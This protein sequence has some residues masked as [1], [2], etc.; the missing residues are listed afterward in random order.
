[1]TP[2]VGIGFDAHPFAAGRSLR[3]GGVV[4]PHPTGLQGHSDGDALLHALTDALLG[5]AGLGSIGDHFPPTDPAWKDADSATFLVRASEFA[6]KHGFSIGNVDAIVIA[7]SPKIAPY[8]ERIR[9]RLAE[10]LG[11]EADVISVRGTSTNGLGF[12]GR[13]EGIAAMAVVLLN[14]KSQLTNHKSP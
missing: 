2:R 8:V 6:G 3:L 7:E 14:R 13:E 1:M 11:V 12:T 9:A 10:I 5:A 4:I